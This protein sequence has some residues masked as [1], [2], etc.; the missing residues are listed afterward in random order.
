MR[1][2]ITA[3][4]II[5]AAVCA[6]VLF[7]RFKPE[8]TAPP[9]GWPK[10]IA[11]YANN[12]KALFYAG[13]GGSGL[14]IAARD[15][16]RFVRP[17]GA[18]ALN[19]PF[20]ASNPA[21]AGAG[22]VCAVFESGGFSVC[23]VNQ[24]ELMYRVTTESPVVTASCNQNGT[25]CVITAGDDAYKTLV[26]GPAGELLSEG[27]FIKGRVTPIN[28]AVSEDSRILALSFL[29]VSA[30]V[31]GSSINFYY[32]N[33]NEA[34]G[35]ADGPF[36]FSGDNPG[37]VFGAMRFFGGS[38]IVCSE[39]AVYMFEP[40]KAEMGKTV[41]PLKNKI[42]AAAIDDGKAAVALGEAAGEGAEPPG[43]V[44]VFDKALRRITEVDFGEEIIR[45]SCGHGGII[46][47]SGSAYAVISGGG[48]T[49]KTPVKA[50]TKAV[51]FI[52]K[53]LIAVCGAAEAEAERID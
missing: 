13:G 11:A 14:F 52:G 26:Y 35:G 32:I 37:G 12:G 4:L 24:N 43:R 17:D 3:L 48:K 20:S 28:C 42:T 19:Q 30:A 7:S 34:K 47:E 45:L 23:V 39:D 44:I 15:G 41:V 9:G 49:S 33:K 25:L 1:A 10:V 29:D 8:Q 50:G 21:L 31:I 53:G 40:D 22:G 6:A 36:A 2:K 27:V 18:E 51:L 16:I 46:A 5:V 38:L